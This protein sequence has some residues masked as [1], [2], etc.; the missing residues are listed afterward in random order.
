M[1]ASPILTAGDAPGS[2]AVSKSFH[3]IRSGPSA[4]NGHGHHDKYLHCA[5]DN[6]TIAA[7]VEAMSAQ[8]HHRPI[9][10]SSHARVCEQER[11]L[12]WQRL[13]LNPLPV[14]AHPQVP[15]R[16]A[17]ASFAIP[18]DRFLTDPLSLHSRVQQRKE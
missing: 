5:V 11:P 4:L 17:L 12:A 9:E 10:G 6:K 16:S 7:L 1:D 15:S 2:T 14:A 8:Q 18:A 13:Q 3:C